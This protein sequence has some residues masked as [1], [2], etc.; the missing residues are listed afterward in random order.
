MNAR[1]LVVDDEPDLAELIRQKFRHQTQKGEVSFLFADGGVEALS[2]LADD[3]KIDLVV[4]DINM[5]RMDGLTLLQNLQESE[6]RLSTVI[7]SAYGDMANIRT[8]MNRG[9]F[10]F[11]TKP[12]VLQDLKTAIAKTLRQSK[13]CER[14]VSAKP[15]PSGLMPLCLGISPRI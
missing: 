12:I 10:D 13:S 2:V 7:V 3:R 14:R 8:A 6:E 4:T 11:V 5:P 9:A 15:Q 1:I